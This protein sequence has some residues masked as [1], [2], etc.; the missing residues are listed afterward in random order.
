MIKDEMRTF[1][2]K[3]YL[4]ERG[5]KMPKLSFM[6]SPLIAQEM[7]RIRKNEALHCKRAIPAGPNQRLHREPRAPQAVR[8]PGVETAHRRASKMPFPNGAASGENQGK[9]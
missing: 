7:E 4:G 8:H 5:L 6:D 9:H 3:D 2:K 1:R